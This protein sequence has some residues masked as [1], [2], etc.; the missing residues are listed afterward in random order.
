MRVCA[1]GAD[2]ERINQFDFFQLGSAIKRLV[3]YPS[4]E[5]RAVQV[6][7]D[8]WTAQGL[9]ENLLDG[10]PIPIVISRAAA[11]DVKSA[12]DHIDN[13]HF[14]EKTES[15]ERKFKWPSPDQK[16]PEWSWNWLRGNLEKFETVFAAEMAEAT[17]YYVPRRGIFFTPSLVEAADESFPKEMLSFIP[18][19][20]KVDWKAAGRC[21]AF[22]LLT[23]SGFHVARAV[24]GIWNP[25]ISFFV[26]SLLARPLMAGQTISTLS[27][28][29]RNP[30]RR[31][32]QRK[33][34]LNWIRCGWTIV[35]Q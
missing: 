24:E 7:S 13:T 1:K 18:D 23:A 6:G 34:S 22:N 3:A 26:I 8:L 21:L 25:T 2:V 14:Y 12:I 31:C 16:I 33:L 19:K 27:G 30:H 20:T 15:G 29:Y 28:R 17:S 10:K 4:E 35:I 32:Q 9:M 5:L 11:R